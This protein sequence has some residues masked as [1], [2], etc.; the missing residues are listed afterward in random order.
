MEE[1][2]TATAMKRVYLI[3]NCII[4]S[5]GSCGGPLLMRLYFLRGG[6]RIWFSSWL[7]TGGWPVTLIP[8]L[9]SYTRRRRAGDRALVV[10]RPRVFLAAAALGATTGLDDYMYAHGVARLPVSTSSL[11]L[12]TQLAFTAA[13]AFV[14]VRQRFTAFS[15]NAVVLLTL[16]AVVLGLHTDGDRPE[17]ESK[18]EYLIGFFLTLIAAALFGLILPAIELIYKRAMQPLTFTLALEIQLVLCFFATAFCTIGMIVNNDF[19]AIPREAKE[20]ELGETRYYV[21]VLCSAIVLQCAF[22][23]AIGVIYYSSSL[24]SGIVISIMLPVTELLA[25]IFF[26]E[27]F[28]AEKERTGTKIWISSTLHHQLLA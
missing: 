1:D 4:L 28:Q 13:F 16:G 19:Q 21:V 27:R 23:G 25:V 15:V 5:V 20:Y 2:K 26:H 6:K 11:I 18:R 8:L 12:A 14:L 9:A 17:G 22:L 10:M 7:Q 24:L 3:I